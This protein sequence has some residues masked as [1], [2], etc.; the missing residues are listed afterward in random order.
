[1]EEHE[2][3][4]IVTEI[5]LWALNNPYFANRH[6]REVIGEHLD[7]SDDVLTE[8]CQIALKTVGALDTTNHKAI[9]EWLD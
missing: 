4:L 7:L 2:Y 1:M 3:N 8:V 9:G 6:F 5:T